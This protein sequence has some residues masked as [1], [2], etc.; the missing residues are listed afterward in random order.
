MSKSTIGGLNEVQKGKAVDR[1][2]ATLKRLS[3]GLMGGSE[4]S[5]DRRQKYPA[6]TNSSLEH[7]SVDTAIEKSLSD[8]ANLKF[9]NL[10]RQSSSKRKKKVLNTKPRFGLPEGFRPRPQGYVRSLL[11]EDNIYRLPDNKEFVPKKPVGPLGKPRH[12]Y[13]LLTVEQVEAGSRGSVYVHA[14]GRIF[15][16]SVD[17]RDPLRDMFDTGYTIHDLERTGRYGP[18]TGSQKKQNEKSKPGRSAHAG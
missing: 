13:A 18:P 15:D 4:E 7:T 12:L 6:Q 10:K 9:A 3:E 11:L 17:H 8:R 2:R 16:Y 5:H 14:D 1:D